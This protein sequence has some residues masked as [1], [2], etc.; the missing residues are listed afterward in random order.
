MIIATVEVLHPDV[1]DGFCIINEEDLTDEHV[2]R[3]S[4]AE[5][6]RRKIMAKDRDNAQGL[7]AIKSDILEPLPEQP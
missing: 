3:D 5:A 4:K 1:P 2:L 7:A 6:K